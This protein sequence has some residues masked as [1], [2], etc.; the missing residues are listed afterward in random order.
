MKFFAPLVLVI[1][2]VAVFF[3]FVDPTYSR[4]KSLSGQ[5]AEYN[6]A[7]TRARELQE[8][9]DRLLSR[10]N[11][12]RDA[13]LSRLQKLLPD[14]IDNVRLVLDIDSIASRYGMRTRNVAVQ[15]E[16][17]LAQA[18]VIG[19][20]QRL[21]GTVVLSFSVTGTYDNFIAFLQ[22]LERSLRLVDV[23]SLSFAARAGTDVY[24]F[25]LAIRTYWLR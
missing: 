3:G 8:T 15:N 23:E 1:I 6:D 9:R 16:A 24:D 17:P 4:I 14:T 5:E 18:G 19:P 10:Y 11:T 20:D 21:Y 12:F 2:A 22:D 25:N 7:L 13:D